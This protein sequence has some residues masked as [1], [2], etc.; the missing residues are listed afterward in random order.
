MLGMSVLLPQRFH[1]HMLELV[2]EPCMN[3]VALFIKRGE[4]LFRGMVE[5]IWYGCND[6]RISTPFLTFNKVT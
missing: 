3:V 6:N 1:F 5:K 4:S 2:G